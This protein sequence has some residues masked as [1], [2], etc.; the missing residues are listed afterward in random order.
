MTIADAARAAGVSP[1]T[2]SSALAGRRVNLR[3]ALALAAA[4]RT[5][6][7][8]DEMANLVACEPP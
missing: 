6:P 7:V 5:R 8:V 4:L 1:A 3:T 2:I